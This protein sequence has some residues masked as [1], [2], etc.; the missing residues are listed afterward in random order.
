[1]K[2][3]IRL[4]LTFLILSHGGYGQTSQNGNDHEQ[5]GSILNYRVAHFEVTDSTLIEA[6]SKLSLEP[7]AGLHLG[8][9]EVLRERFSEVPDRSI[10][11]SLT[12]E[13]STVRDIV[14]ALC[15][16]DSRYTLV[17]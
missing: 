2:T 13:N 1:M 17:H 15:Q 4:L 7:I 14:E 10:R 6:L 11:F 16:V 12:L 5:S 3:L 8:I 9:E